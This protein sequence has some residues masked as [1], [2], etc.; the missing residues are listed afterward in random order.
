MRSWLKM[1][2]RNLSMHRLRSAMTLFGIGL[3]VALILAIQIA[4][5]SM[6]TSIQAQTA[7]LFGQADVRIEVPADSDAV[8]S[9][10]QIAKVTEQADVRESLASLSGY[11]MQDGTE[12]TPFQVTGV[13][14]SRAQ[15]FHSYD[16]VS[17]QWLSGDSANEVL[18]GSET[19]KNKNLQVGN[20]IKLTNGSKTVDLKIAGLLS[21]VGD[22]AS[23]IGDAGLVPLSV[24]QDLLGQANGVNR[25]DIAL[26]KTADKSAFLNE[27][28]NL[29][30]GAD[31]T[32]QTTASE[33]IRASLNDLQS[34]LLFLTVI[35]VFLGGFII[36][37]T[38]TV[39]IAQRMKEIGTFRALGATRGN[40]MQMILTESLV[41]AVFGI[42]F[43]I[44]LGIGLGYLILQLFSQSVSAGSTTF[45]VPPSGVLLASSI[46]LVVTMAAA[47]VPTWRA[48]RSTPMEAFAQSHSHVDAP[49][50]RLPWKRALLGLLLIIGGTIAWNT[51]DVNT[52]QMSVLAILVVIVGIVLLIPVVVRPLLLL[53]GVMLGALFGMKGRFAALNLL[54]SKQRTTTTISMVIVAI[55]T[56]VGLNTLTNAVQSG[57][58][59]QY[60]KMIGFDLAVYPSVAKTTFEDSFRDK[61]NNVEGVELATPFNMAFREDDQL[62]RNVRING[63]VMDEYYKMFTIITPDGFAEPDMRQINSGQGITISEKVAKDRNLTIGDSYEFKTATGTKTMPISG[64][65]KETDSGG[66]TITIPQALF[67]EVYQPKGRGGFFVKKAGDITSGELRD[68]MIAEQLTPAVRILTMEDTLNRISGTLSQMFMPFNA[69]SVIAV[70]VAMLGISNNLLIT[71][72]ERK[73]E[74]GVLR[75]IGSDKGQVR[76]LIL[77]EGGVI[78]LI[79]ILAGYPAGLYLGYLMISWWQKSVEADVTYQLPLA[80]LG[81]GCIVT[82]LLTMLVSVFPARRAA[83][84]DIVESY[85]S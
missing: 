6:N 58:L 35:S 66:Y 5:T 27:T 31:V 49:D 29:V 45:E 11:V 2:F 65:Y 80:W 40:I 36:F 26:Q 4:N 64:V 3:G 72:M 77:T 28:K 69:I 12:A 43:G 19:A 10:E 33:K 73:K 25:I 56:I 39:I 14:V 30:P 48:G 1:G 57:W 52:Q 34:G 32:D 51:F 85:L 74:I 9:D 38:F 55:S 68:A 67:D 22:G 76:S 24:S 63:V 13:D 53:A 44:L 78:G 21:G 60:Q 47:F 7:N 83:N 41:M 46:G 84:M 81:I 82:I 62:D 23:L 17:G 75:S 79:G 42:G 18:I 61:L 37:N 8:L 16:L 50:E 71:V 70:L 15:S 20:T 59:D 54:R